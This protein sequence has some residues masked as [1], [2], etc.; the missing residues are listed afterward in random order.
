[1]KKLLKIVGW[2]VLVIVVLG[3]GAFLVAR[4]IALGKYE[5]QWTVHDATFPIPF[6]LKDDEAESIRNAGGDPGAVALDRA[7]TH[8]ERLIN[9][10]VGCNAC[11]GRDFGGGV[12]VDV[13]PVGYL[14]APN[15]TSGD[16]S[17]TRGFT[18][19]EWDHAVRHGV[20][21]TG[22][23]SAMPSQEFVTLSDHELS[24]IVAY[25]TSRPPVNRQIKPV[26]L[27]PVFAFL[28]ASDPKSLAA[29]GIDHQ[30]PHAVEPPPEVVSVELGEH[31]V[32]ACRGCHG[33]HLSG[34]KIS[35]DPN[36]P[37]VANITPHE[38]GLKDWTEADFL[39]ALREGVR[40]DGTAI[41]TAMPWQQFGK[42]ND[43]ELKAVWAYLRTVPPV[44]KGNH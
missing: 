28:V 26:R 41:K 6:P 21:H 3:I 44:A 31:I 29:F 11:H 16:G 13:L 20:R 35:G 36:M 10:R 40:K 39:R 12:M 2:A 43:V 1:M 18:A 30:K 8:G 19:R 34:G 42:M 32:Q 4:S 38:T 23:S 9:T 25:I 17:I 7:R 27:G 24:D 37:I 22:R 15:L 14:A 5:Q 33:D